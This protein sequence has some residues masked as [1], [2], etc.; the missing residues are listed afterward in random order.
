MR[1]R[2]IFAENAITRPCI[3]TPSGTMMGC[4]SLLAGWRRI[5]PPASRKTLQGRS[6]YRRS[7]N[8]D[9][10]GIRHLR[11]LPHNIVAIEDVVFN[12]GTPLT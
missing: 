7:R 2:S 12:H 10:A 3:F 5:F 11:L 4:I 9:F 6:Q 1:W 8:D